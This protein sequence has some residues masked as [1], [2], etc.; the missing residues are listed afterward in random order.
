MV[1]VKH[2]YYT[3]LAFKDDATA[4]VMQAHLRTEEVL[5][6]SGVTYTII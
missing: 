1:G 4:G 3:S 5:K 2:I 6:K